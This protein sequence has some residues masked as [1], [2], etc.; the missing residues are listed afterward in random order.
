MKNNFSCLT[1]KILQEMEAAMLRDLRVK[2]IVKPEDCISIPN[3]GATGV[4]PSL[5][6]AQY[7]DAV[8]V[9]CEYHSTDGSPIITAFT[10]EL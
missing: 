2:C 10:H 9:G 8:V 1:T 6:V 5:V 4:G 3:S 7:D